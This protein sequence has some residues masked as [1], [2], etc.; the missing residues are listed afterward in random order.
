M[1]VVAYCRDIIRLFNLKI[2]DAV[3]DWVYVN[4]A[5]RIQPPV[6]LL[7][8]RPAIVKLR[9]S[10]AGACHTTKIGVRSCGDKLTWSYK[11]HS[12]LQHLRFAESPLHRYEIVSGCILVFDQHKKDQFLLVQQ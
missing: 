10:G 2:G 3:G 11:A 4:K 8:S 1:V 9:Q 6:P 5:G 12:G 7:V